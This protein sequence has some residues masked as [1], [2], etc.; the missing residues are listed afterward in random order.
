MS[1]FSKTG[2]GYSDLPPADISRLFQSYAQQ[3]S[4]KNFK[5]YD[6]S[7]ELSLRD[8]LNS[9]QILSHYRVVHLGANHI[10]LLRN[11]PWKREASFR[12]KIN[13]IPEN[14]RTR[15]DYKITFYPDL[16]LMVVPFV[17]AFLAAQEPKS[18]FLIIPFVTIMT[19]LGMSLEKGRFLSWFQNILTPPSPH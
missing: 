11:P 18:L 3:C 5:K 14:P 13:W 1:F 19:A 17:L 12:I 16:S 15:L 7:M 8:G 10:E 9:C 4:S 2:H 6:Q